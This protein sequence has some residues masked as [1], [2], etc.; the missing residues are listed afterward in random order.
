L[1]REGCL[2]GGFATL[3]VRCAIVDPHTQICTEE[4]ASTVPSRKRV[5]DTAPRP[6]AGQAGSGWTEVPPP[7]AGVGVGDPATLGGLK[8]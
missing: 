5:S 7:G 2:F 1:A 4:N 8:E 3:C 6:L